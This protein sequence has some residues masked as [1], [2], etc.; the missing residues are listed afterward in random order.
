M[1]KILTLISIA[2]LAAGCEADF[3]PEQQS[4][5]VVSPSDVTIK[6]SNVGDNSFSFTMSTEGE[7]AYYSYLVDESEAP[8]TESF[9]PSTLYQV[10]YSSVAQGTVKWTSESPQATVTVEGLSP[11]TVYQV[12]AVVG[13][14]TGVPSSIAAVTVTTSDKVAPVLSDYEYA[15]KSVTLTYSE[16]ISLASETGNS[17]TV[18]YYAINSTEIESGTEMNTVTGTVSVSGSQATVA[19]EGLPDGAYY[20]VDIPAG[21]FK[22]ASDNKSAAVTST[23]QLVYDP[24][25]GPTLDAKGIYGQVTPVPFSL[26]TPESE[27][28]TDWETPVSVTPENKYQIIGAYSSVTGTAVYTSDGKTTTYT[29]TPNTD[30]GYS[31]GSVAFYLPEE[32]ARGDRVTLNVAAETFE[33][34]YGNTNAEWSASFVYS[35]GYTTADVIGTYNLSG[36]PAFMGD[37]SLSSTMTI[38]ESDNAENGNVMI[39]VFAGYTC[40]PSIYGTF[41]VNTGTLTIPAM[42]KF[43]AKEDVEFQVSETQSITM[44][45]DLRLVLGVISGGSLSPDSRSPIVFNM[46]MSGTLIN[47]EDYIGILYTTG[48]GTEMQAVSWETAYYNVVASKGSSGGTISLQSTGKSHIMKKSFVR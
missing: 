22:D 29:M 11:N 21:M 17:V 30:F 19:F 33:D 18:K 8:Q 34:I 25:Q 15:D 5:S 43:Y 16:S 32:P 27:A 39:T 3:V 10:G 31:S 41:D 28:I 2:A 9:D 13:S 4:T 44:D 20:T 40:S 1:K 37:A 45:V 48:T 35:Y 24:S 14:P 6:T 7:A 12:Y 46:P 26:G 47:T 42:Q 38:A 36:D 23:M